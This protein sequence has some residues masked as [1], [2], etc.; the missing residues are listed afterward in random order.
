MPQ[1]VH[2]R[3]TSS[4]RFMILSLS[5]HPHRPVYHLNPGAVIPA[6]LFII[7]IPEQ[8]SPMPCLSSLSRSSHLRC[9]VSFFQ[10]FHQ[11]ICTVHCHALVSYSALSKKGSDIRAL[12]VC[13]VYSDSLLDRKSPSPYSGTGML[14]GLHRHVLSRMRRGSAQMCRL[15]LMR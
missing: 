9:P 4:A 8:P 10:Y 11:I 3:G 15:R 12:R 1:H 7:F 14:Q 6:A 5:S 2:N 13:Y